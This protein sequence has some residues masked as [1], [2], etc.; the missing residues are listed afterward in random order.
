MTL[1]SL[2]IGLMSHPYCLRPL[3][4]DT[5][6]SGDVLLAKHVNCPDNEM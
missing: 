2:L 6:M 1:E 4:K 5:A 3:T